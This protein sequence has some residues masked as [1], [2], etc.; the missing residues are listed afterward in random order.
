LWTLKLLL[1]KVGHQIG[2]TASVP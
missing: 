2:N 1:I